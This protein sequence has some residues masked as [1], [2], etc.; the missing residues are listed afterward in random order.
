[1]WCGAVVEGKDE[2]LR[3]REDPVEVEN[4]P[5]TGP[6]P[7]KDALRIISLNHGEIGH[8]IYLTESFLPRTRVYLV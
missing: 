5:Y 2:L 6:D 1:L 4:I 7:G 8:R 3:T